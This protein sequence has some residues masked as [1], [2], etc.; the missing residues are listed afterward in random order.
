MERK[1][2][3]EA[4]SEKASVVQARLNWQVACRDDEKVAQAL[5]AGE[6]IE[7]MHEL[8]DAG[9]LD[10]FF[11][12]LK[13]LGMLEAFEQVSVTGVQRT[14][15][16]T[17]QFVLLYFL[18]VLLGGESM[19]ELPRVLFSDLAL[20]ELVGFN[21]H[22]CENG[23][24]KRGD[25]R[26]L[27][28]KKQGPITAQC[29]ADNICKLT[30]GEMERL[31]NLM[32]HLLARRGWFTGNLLVALDG[33]KVPTPQSYEGCGKL[34]Q[35]RKVKVKGQKEPMTEEYYLYGWKVLVLI[36]VQTRLPLAMKLVPI[37][38]YEG[39][40][41]VPLLEQA[42]QNLGPHAQIGTIVVDRGY[43]DGEDL[44]RVHQ[45]GVTFVICGKSSMAVTQDAQGLASR[46]RASVRERV[47]RRGHGK[48]ATDQ[49]L[50]TELVG[51]EALTSYDQYGERA[52]TQHAHRTDYVGQPINAVVVRK[53]EN[54]VPKTGGTVYLTN[55]AVDD[56]FVVFD[57]YDWRSVIENGIFKEGKHPW[58]LLHF[59]KRTE[60]AVV[61]HCHLTLLVMG[62]TTAFRLW[63]KQQAIA[64]KA[65]T[66]VLPTL[67]SALL[68]GEGIARWRKR[69]EEENRDKII[70]FIG[71][72]YGIFHLAEFAVLTH[73]PIRRLPASLGSP[74]AIL[75]RF[76]ISP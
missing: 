9:L 39:K 76:G 61:V 33:S 66:S 56:P 3:T 55:G 57:T 44:W 51:I 43:L 7:E 1:Q 41:L 74:Q 15:V 68:G 18:K 54:H 24:T 63:Q 58:H 65:R 49:R 46:E 37:Q 14:L 11:V 21:A 60:G 73:V 23:V 31:F 34:K 26:R 27:T 35:T 64:P 36:E 62:L 29:L 8:S 75:Q 67:S 38:E 4:L 10:E 47:V 20:M 13:D 72:D 12:F 53:W 52:D 70:V 30:Q 25:A 2:L 48:T 40:W 69:L 32:V 42:Q 50:R 17:V 28:K 6:T 22:Q 5:Y 59:P 16:P 71:Q 45:K 19:N